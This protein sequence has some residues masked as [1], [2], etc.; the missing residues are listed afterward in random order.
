[1]IAEAKTFS[2]AKSKAKEV[3]FLAVQSD[4]ESESFAGFWLLQ[5][6]NI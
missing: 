2:E 1:M 3:H 4:P 5:E 6:I